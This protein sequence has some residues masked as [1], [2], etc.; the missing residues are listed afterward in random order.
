[1]IVLDTVMRDMPDLLF[2]DRLWRK[3]NNPK[4][5]VHSFLRQNSRFE[6]DDEFD[7]KLFLSARHNGYL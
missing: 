3:S 2:K 4:T 1:M 5:A 7:N 6:V